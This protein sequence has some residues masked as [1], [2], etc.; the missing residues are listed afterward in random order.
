METP[1]FGGG[2]GGGFDPNAFGGDFGGTPAPDF[3]ADT[4]MG[5][6]GGVQQPP[7]MAPPPPR[8]GVGVLALV[9][10]AIIALIAGIFGGPFI[11]DQDFMA[12]MP[13]PAKAKLE[14]AQ[15]ESMMKDGTIGQLRQQLDELMRTIRP[16]G[17]DG[18]TVISQEELDRLRGEIISAQN[19]LGTTQQSLQ[20]AKT[21]LASVERDLQQKSEEVFE[22]QERFTTLETATKITQAR[23]DGLEAES[24]RLTEMVGALDDAAVRSNASRDALLHNVERLL[25]QVREGMPLTPEK[26][27]HATR[28]ADIEALRT[29][30]AE[31]KWV[32]PALMNEYNAAIQKEIDIAKSSEYFFAKLTVTDRFGTRVEKWAEC[33]MNG[34]WSVYYRTLDGKNIGVFENLAEVGENPLWGLNEG[35]PKDALTSIEARVVNARVPDFQEKVEF[36]AAKQLAEQ[37]E[38]NYQRNFE[39]LY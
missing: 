29:Q 39:S 11:A 12:W 10:I 33:V 16:T 3:G 6:R 27:D 22:A 26:Y 13:N 25:A 1:L 14:Q 38:T 37:G 32:T 28:V 36:L 24:E 9:I 21:N 31:A 18:G 19:E 17:E 20:D 30:V 4:G 23:R 7:M 5:G 15:Q 8:G 2:S 35:L 34:N